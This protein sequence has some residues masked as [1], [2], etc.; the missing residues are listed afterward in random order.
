VPLLLAIVDNHGYGWELATRVNI[1]DISLM[2]DLIAIPPLPIP[3][4]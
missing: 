4:S 1:F 3:L 2:K